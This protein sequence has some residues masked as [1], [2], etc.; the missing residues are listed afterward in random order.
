VVCFYNPTQ[1]KYE[2]VYSEEG[3][4]IQWVKVVTDVS[5]KKSFLFVDRLTADGQQGLKAYA[6]LNNAIQPVLEAQ[7]AHVYAGFLND[8][9]GFSVLCSD[10]VIPQSETD[11]EHLFKWNDGKSLFVEAPSTAAVGWTGSSIAGAESVAAVVTPVASI[12]QS[13]SAVVTPVVVISTPAPVAVSTGSKD[14]W[15][16]PFDAAGASAKLDN[17]IVPQA[18][19]AGQMAVLGKKANSFFQKAREQ[20]VGAPVLAKMRAGYYLAVASTLSGMGRDK[21]A[22]YYLD[23]ALKLDPSNAQ[24]LDL[25][26]KLK[27]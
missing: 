22:A 17:E 27:S 26:M 12:P 10:K 3:Q 14:W 2:K 20:G 13:S 7:A 16:S 15:G 1:K 23:L 4:A 9:K 18:V 6:C 8:E 11:A 5:A 25:K 24:A 19:K 21:D